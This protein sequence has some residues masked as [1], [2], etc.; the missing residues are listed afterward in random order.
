VRTSWR[1]A[2][3]VPLWAAISILGCGE[4]TTGPDERDRF[5]PQFSHDG[6]RYYRL[7]EDG[8]VRRIDNFV[9]VPTSATRATIYPSRYMGTGNP[10]SISYTFS[11]PVIDLTAGPQIETNDHCPATTPMTYR[12]YGPDDG[13]L[14]S[15]I[16]TS[17]CGTGP[18]HLTYRGPVKRLVITPPDPMPADYGGGHAMW[19][20]LDFNM[21]CPLTGDPQLDDA[22]NKS[23]MDSSFQASNP[24]GP[25]LDRREHLRAGYRFP[26]GHIESV[27]LNPPSA[28]NCDI[29]NASVPLTNGDGK[30]IWLWHSHP[31]TPGELVAHC[32]G[33]EPFDQPQPYP[34]A[35]S[36]RDWQFLDAINYQLW[37]AFESPIPG[38]I[39]DKTQTMRMDPNVIG[40][41]PKFNVKSFNRPGPN[42]CSQS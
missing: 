4:R 20:S 39:Y 17:I 24:N 11:V 21:Q 14:E 19:C 31:F 8:I 38:Y 7:W 34:S 3:A 6:F 29:P 37:L 16:F 13:L 12:A 41:Q 25:Q 18:V 22:V 1:L 27:D 9:W 35:P 26:D 15:G 10:D 30:L 5:R 36:P 2:L 33:Y 42:E 28:A 32:L 40:E 23:K